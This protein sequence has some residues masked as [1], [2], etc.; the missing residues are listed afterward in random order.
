MSSTHPPPP[1]PPP[2]AIVQFSTVAYITLVGGK[3]SR[4]GEEGVEY[5]GL[6]E[7]DYKEGLVN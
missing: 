4:S 5:E 7:P 1:S 2:P 3:P 6:V